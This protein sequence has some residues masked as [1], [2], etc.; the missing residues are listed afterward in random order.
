MPANKPRH[1]NLHFNFVQDLLLNNGI[2]LKYVK[3][4]NITTD[5]LRKAII[6]EDKFA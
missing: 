3:S 5:F 2:I 6:K 1:M 4:K